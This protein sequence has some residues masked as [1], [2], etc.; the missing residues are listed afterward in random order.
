[1]IKSMT[2]KSLMTGPSSNNQAARW[3]FVVVQEVWGS[4]G[5]KLPRR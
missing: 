5:E 2:T 1:M 4:L 3:P